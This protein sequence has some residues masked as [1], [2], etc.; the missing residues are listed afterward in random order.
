MPEGEWMREY[1]LSWIERMAVNVLRRGRVPRHIAVIMDG[2]RRFARLAGEQ[3][4]MG[5]KAGFEKL[6]DTLQW[7]RQMGIREVTVYAFSIENFNRA[8]SEV[9]DLLSLARDKFVKLLDETEKLKQAGVRVRIIGNLRYL[10]EDLQQIIKEVEE[11]TKDNSESLLNIAMSYTARDEISHAVR[12]T[13]KDVVNGD[14][15]IDDV[16]EEMIQNH[17]YTESSPPPD[18]LIRTSGETRLSD[19]MLWQ[20]S[21]SITYFTPVLW[22]EFTLWQLLS[23]IFLFQRQHQKLEKLESLTAHAQNEDQEDEKWQLLEQRRQVAN[24]LDTWA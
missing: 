22:P 17:L 19:F 10:P 8:E 13:V 6:A 18:L 15:D 4:I 2:N 23:G 12:E 21:K 20:A 5:H 14:F 7:C 9:S 11:V 24:L 3:V 16:D 1:E